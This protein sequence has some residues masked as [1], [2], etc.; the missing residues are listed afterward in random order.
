[1]S[2]NIMNSHSRTPF[3]N[4]LEDGETGDISDY[5]GDFDNYWNQEGVYESETDKGDESVRQ[6]EE[7]VDRYWAAREEEYYWEV[8]EISYEACK[9]CITEQE[10]H[11]AEHANDSY[12]RLKKV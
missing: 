9:V 3:G 10:R 2:N 6:E 11:D 4:S 8:Q 12:Y 1:M 7:A 5:D